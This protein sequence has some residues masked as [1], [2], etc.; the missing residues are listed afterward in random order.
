MALVL[1]WIILKSMWAAHARHATGG[2]FSSRTSGG[3]LAA[4]SI[5]RVPQTFASNVLPTAPARRLCSQLI[6]TSP[7]SFCPPV[8]SMHQPSISG[9]YYQQGRLPS[10]TACSPTTKTASQPPEHG[11]TPLTPDERSNCSG[12]WRAHVSPLPSHS[13]LF[14]QDVDLSLRSPVVLILAPGHL[15]R[16]YLTNSRIPTRPLLWTYYS[17]CHYRPPSPTC[18][19]SHIVFLDHTRV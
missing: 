3:C 5:V 2:V 9:Q 16:T 13:L 11:T 15:C 17:S 12:H 10:H 18:Q 6:T 4:K 19:S 7:L 14:P 1:T 8:R